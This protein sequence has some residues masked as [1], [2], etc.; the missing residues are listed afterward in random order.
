NP[1]PRACFVGG[2]RVWVDGRLVEVSQ[3]CAGQKAG[4]LD[5]LARTSGMHE[6]EGVQE[7]EGTYDCY[8]V[9]LATGEVITVA[10]EH[11]FLVNGDFEQWVSVH[12]LKPGSILKSL[13]GPVRVTAVL[14]RPAPLAGKVYNLKIKNSDRYFVGRSGIT[15]RD[16]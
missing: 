3:V 4:R 15:V 8:D 10:D 2:T 12:D 1:K 16:Y 9:V 7:H 13:S 14:R 6:I 11:Y 5:C